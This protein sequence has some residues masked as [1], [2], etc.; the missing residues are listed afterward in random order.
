MQTF[1]NQQNKILPFQILFCDFSDNSTLP[2]GFTGVDAIIFDVGLFHSLWGISGCVA[3][4][5]DGGYGRFA[6]CVSHTLSLVVCLPCAF[7]NR[8]KPFYMWPLLIQVMK[9]ICNEVN[10]AIFSKALMEL[11][12]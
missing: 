1:K 4:H 5:L 3:Q 7:M 11:G 2:A 8:P 10:L 9:R 6:W 12:C